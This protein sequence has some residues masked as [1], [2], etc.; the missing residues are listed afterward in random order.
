MAKLTAGRHKWPMQAHDYYFFGR[1]S[2]RTSRPRNVADAA[3]QDLLCRVCEL[4]VLPKR[5]GITFA[6]GFAT[7]THNSTVE[8]GSHVT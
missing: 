8:G 5:W 3:K 1:K 4:P 2:W 6:S 7:R